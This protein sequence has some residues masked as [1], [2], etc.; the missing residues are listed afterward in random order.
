MSEQM[1]FQSTGGQAPKA[2][3]AL[4]VI[5]SLIGFTAVIAQVVLMRELLVVFYGNELALGVTLANWLLWTALG[6]SL[7]GRWAMSSGHPRKLVAGLQV[8]LAF[9]LPLTLLAVR[10]SKGFCQSI[11]GEI[12]GPV[13]MILT[14]CA[15]LS[16]FCVISGGL[17]AAGSR[18]FADMTG[19]S[20][21]TATGAVYLLEAAGSG[22]GG[23]IA[24][25]GLVRLANPFEIT[26][27]LGVLNLLAAW[28]LLS[29]TGAHRRALAASFVAMAALIAMGSYELQP[30]SLARLWR[31]FHLVSAQNS[32]YGSLAVVET[33]ASRSLFENGLIVMTVPDPAAAEEAVHFALLEHPEPRSLLLIGGGVNGSIAEALTHPSLERLD[34][35]ELDP[36]IFDIAAQYFPKEWGT[37]RRDSRVRIHAMDGRRFLKS[38]EDSFDVIIVNLPDPHTAQ[39]NRFYTEEFYRQAAAKL[40]PGGIVSFQVTSSENYINQ[41]LADFLRCLQRTLRQVFPEVIAIPGETV[42]FFAAAKPGTLTADP[43]ELLRRLRARRLHTQYVR[44]YFLPFRMSPDRMQD[45]QLQIAPL[46]ST[47]VNRDFAP[48][49]YYFDVALWSAPFHQTSAHWFEALASICFER[50]LLATILALAALVPLLWMWP[51]GRGGKPA[52][53][54]RRSAA[55]AAAVVGFTELGLEILL[56]LGFQALYGYVYHELTILVALF[57]VGVALGAWWALH[58]APSLG[59][60]SSRRDLRLLAG[61]QILLAAS[62]LLLYAVLVQLG[63]VSSA[64]GQRAASELL[65]PALALVAGLL[66]GFQF[67][68][69]TRAYFGDAPESGRSPGVLY[70]LDLAGACAGALALSILLIPIYGF[71]RTAAFMAAV[72]L[73][74]ALMAAASGSDRLA[75][76][77]GLS[78]Q[79]SARQ[80]PT[81]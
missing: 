16:V 80:K 65:F 49:A 64:G 28:A 40:N 78:Q 75:V 47:P 48:V 46:P 77:E 36:M 72:N 60:T 13:P 29:P 73:A 38:T 11:P 20:T 52:A 53:R 67:L 33:G 9:A 19:A 2:T 62:P 39:L 24:G 66:G 30:L 42:H 10:V 51:V 21:A 37:I 1:S 59:G 4:R 7:L 56:L 61:L 23:V 45:L 26:A 15:T 71:L 8:L 34:Y 18:L 50:F 74:P 41:E 22:V 54:A 69:A 25:L 12:L 81:P 44:E 55:F 27:L 58:S 79:A 14:S 43:Q 17:F 68:L 32:V 5:L 63:R 3:R 31:G 57:M 70:A 76:Q 6:A 35:V